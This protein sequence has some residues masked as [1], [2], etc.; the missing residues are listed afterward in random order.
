MN[1]LRFAP[2]GRALLLVVGVTGLSAC[3]SRLA[4][5]SDTDLQDRMYECNTTVDQSPGMA[6]SC[7]NYRR[8]CQRRRDEGRFVC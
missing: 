3:E 1:W 2:P 6:I 4:G 5:L 8:E 7:D